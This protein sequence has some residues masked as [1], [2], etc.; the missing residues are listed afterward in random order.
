MSDRR[1]D[2][3][4]VCARP[5]RADRPDDAHPAVAGRR[6]QRT[7][8]RSITP[9]RGTVELVAEELQ[10]RRRSRVARDYDQLDVV[11]F[12][13]LPRDLAGEA[14]HLVEALGAVG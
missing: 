3:P 8:P 6:Q 10:G 7:H 12:D 9:T 13:Q 11:L 1:P 4:L 2:S 5:D 14:A